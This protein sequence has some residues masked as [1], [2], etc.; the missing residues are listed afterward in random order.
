MCRALAAAASTAGVVAYGLVCPV[1]RAAEVLLRLENAADPNPPRP[2]CLTLLYMFLLLLGMLALFPLIVLLL[3]VAAVGGCLGTTCQD[4][5]QFL[6]DADVR[7]RLMRG[8]TDTT[9]PLHRPMSAYLFFGRRSDRLPV[10]Q[11]PEHFSGAHAQRHTVVPLREG[12]ALCVGPGAA[13][14]LLRVSDLL[15]AR[16]LV[17]DG[18]VAQSVPALA[19]AAVLQGCEPA[20]VGVRYMYVL[21]EAAVVIQRA[22]RHAVSDP[23][24]SVC[25]ARL[26]WE[27]RQ[28]S[29]QQEE[30]GV[31]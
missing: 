16:R 5:S 27:W 2:T 28:L 9:T 12:W 24:H 14:C 15:L 11:L 20:S 4:L 22:W 29:D 17:V 3:V 30:E 18:E 13:P 26:L 19:L 7:R 1:L 6:Q 31:L 8:T 10:V 21:Q 23:R 25:R